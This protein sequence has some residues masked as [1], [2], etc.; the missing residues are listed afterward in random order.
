MESVAVQACGCEFTYTRAAAAIKHG[1]LTGSMKQS[2]FAPVTLLLADVAGLA[3]SFNSH[4]GCIIRQDQNRISF[5]DLDEPELLHEIRQ[6]IRRKLFSDMSHKHQECDGF[7]VKVL[8]WTFV[9]SFCESSIQ[10]ALIGFR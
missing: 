7:R 10:A 5:K 2:L 9:V 1:D 4:D 8:I 6:L 3:C